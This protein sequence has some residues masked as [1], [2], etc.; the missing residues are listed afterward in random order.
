VVMAMVGQEWGGRSSSYVLT[1][2][3]DGR[4]MAMSGPGETDSHRALRSD[5]HGK[6]GNGGSQP[7]VGQEVGPGVHRALFSDPTARMVE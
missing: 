1:P 6:D 5:P 3:Q 4:V 2:Q 7:M